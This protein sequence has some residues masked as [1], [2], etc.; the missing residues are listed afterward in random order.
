M[1]W[2]SCAHAGFALGSWWCSRWP[3]FP[4]ILILGICSP[5]V[6]IS[7][8][9]IDVQM[10]TFLLGK[11]GLIRRNVFRSQQIYRLP[12]VLSQQSALLPTHIEHLCAFQS[13]KR[14]I[15]IISRALLYYQAFRLLLW[16]RECR[17][18]KLQM[19]RPSLGLQAFGKSEQHGKRSQKRQ[20]YCRPLRHQACKRF[21]SGLN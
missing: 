10:T 13:V 17:G 20:R 4:A 16:S 6:K 1:P 12:N 21:C 11:L 18:L 15:Q 5:P 8:H 9:Q 2:S 7:G 14:I 19:R 3:T